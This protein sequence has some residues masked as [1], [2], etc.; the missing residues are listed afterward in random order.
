MTE[1]MTFPDLIPVVTRPISALSPFLI[2]RQR[3]IV[4][5][6]MSSS[7]SPMLQSRYTNVIKGGVAHA[8]NLR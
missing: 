7:W 4:K 2:F 8:Q 3:S 1:V 6:R 5:C